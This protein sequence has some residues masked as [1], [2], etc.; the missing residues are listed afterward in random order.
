M[1]TG[2]TK[3]VC[4]IGVSLLLW[5]TAALAQENPPSQSEHYFDDFNGGSDNTIDLCGYYHVLT[6]GLGAG[7]TAPIPSPFPSGGIFRCISDD[8]DWG[9]PKNKW[10]DRAWFPENTGLAMTLWTGNTVVYE[11]HG[12]EHRQTGRFYDAEPDAAGALAGFTPGMSSF[13]SMSNNYDLIEASYFIV[14]EPVTFD[15][16]SGYFACVD[17]FEP[18]SP[19]VS[20]RMNIW[21]AVR[22]PES[23]DVPEPANESFTGDVFSQEYIDGEFEHAKTEISREWT[24]LEKDAKP[25]WRL[26][27]KLEKPMTLEPGEYFFSHDAVLHKGGF[28]FFSPI[29]AL[30]FGLVGAG[31]DG[32]PFRGLLGLALMI[33][34]CEPHGR[35]V[36]EPATLTLAGLA[37]GVAGA[38]R[39]ASRIGRRRS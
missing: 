29:A 39:V 18:G 36:P 26:T 35:V 4:V 28:L 20:Y 8:P 7:G 31:S 37:A 30:P 33:P 13:F 34:P 14:K 3:A 12:I 10:Q 15:R 27:Y 5:A 19:L 24:G 32:R 6:T 11:N 21:H 22:T 16:I 17:G 23:G 2:R 9:F 1:N 25:V 38:F